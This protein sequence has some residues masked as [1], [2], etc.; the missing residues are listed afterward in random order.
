MTDATTLSKCTVD[1]KTPTV[2]MGLDT[3]ES[4][5]LE[6]SADGKCAIEA[7]TVYGVMHGME[8]FVQ[9]LSRTQG[10]ATTVSALAC[11]TYARSRA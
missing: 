3:D 4:Y 5:T 11:M 6:I 8:T 7:P 2:A 1:V 9:L 10:G